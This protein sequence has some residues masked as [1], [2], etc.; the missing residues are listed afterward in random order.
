MG[1][2]QTDYNPKAYNEYPE[3]AANAVRDYKQLLYWRALTRQ[4]G[5][6]MGLMADAPVQTSLGAGRGVP[7]S[8]TIRVR[9]NRG[10]NARGN[11]RV[12]S[13]EEYHTVFDADTIGSPSLP[14][15]LGTAWHELGH[16]I[17]TEFNMPGDRQ[18]TLGLNLLED[19]R[20][21]T[22]MLLRFPKTRGAMLASLHHYL[23]TVSNDALFTYA[24]VVGRAHL[25]VKIRQRLR[26]LA[27]AG[28][29]PIKVH[30]VERIF[31]EYLALGSEIRGNAGNLATAFRLADELDAILST[32]K[33]SARCASVANRSGIN[34]K[35]K[36]DDL[37]E[38]PPDMLDLPEEGEGDIGAPGG[39]AVSGPDLH[40][41]DVLNDL[42]EYLI[43]EVEN[44]E[45]LRA[46]VAQI[47]R[48][49]SS[50]G[51][52]SIVKNTY[53]TSPSPSATRLAKDVRKAAM[54]FNDESGKGLVR[55]RGSGRLR[56]LRLEQTDDLDIAYDQWEPGLDQ[57]MFIG[58]LMD[59]S[60]SMSSSPVSEIL[61][62][63]EVGL[64]E[65][66]TCKVVYFN[67]RYSEPSVGNTA[68][69]QVAVVC[70]GST[71]PAGGLAYLHGEMLRSS[72]HNRILVLYTDGVFDGM[73]SYIATDA[74][75]KD[76]RKNGVNVRVIGELSGVDL[77]YMKRLVYLQ[78]HELRLVKGISELPQ[79]VLEWTTTILGKGA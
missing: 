39:G 24:W 61:Y 59:V 44:D 79:V 16:I 67:D 27:R 28:A 69:R 13:G 3:D 65:V 35:P 54:G 10:F 50:G 1:N 19:A 15:W 49:L 57:E 32:D 73:D 31:K 74:F 14:V 75:L 6:S 25:P 11:K 21:E 68:H 42:K 7:A 55:R 58:L 30:R 37:V 22:L 78:P 36:E 4:L 51:G 18:V 62:G 47:K 23:R 17:W 77:S 48:Y 41:A 72:V 45:D 53:T 56:P 5:I 40:P 9:L 34:V 52:G 46:E 20:I 33:A 43:E 2:R 12:T 76:L 26:K 29:N 64:S 70:A 66:A 60:G 8:T 38:V 71:D 63:L